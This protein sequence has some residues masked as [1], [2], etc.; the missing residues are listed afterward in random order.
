MVCLAIL[1]LYCA[2][3]SG[4]LSLLAGITEFG[5]LNII[6]VTAVVF[7]WRH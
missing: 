4:I 1:F 5:V 7:A 3:T 6:L 2:I